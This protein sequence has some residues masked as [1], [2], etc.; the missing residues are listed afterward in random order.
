MISGQIAHDQYFSS[1]FKHTASI[2]VF[3]EAMKG[4]ILK[5]SCWMPGKLHFSFM[6]KAICLLQAKSQFLELLSSLVA[7]GLERLVFFSV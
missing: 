4:F 5:F 7:I 1:G 6:W 2:I 3:N